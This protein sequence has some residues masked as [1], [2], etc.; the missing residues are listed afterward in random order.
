MGGLMSFDSVPI[1]VVLL[2]TI[3]LVAL[4]LEAGIRLGRR[5]QRQ[6]GGKSEVSGAMVGATMGLL[7]FMLAFTFNGAAGRHDTRKGLV[8]E[9]TNA[10]DKA[11]LRAG[12]LD[13]PSRAAV[14][15][16]LRNYVDL[17]VKAAGG[18]M[19]LGEAARRSEALLDKMWA[20]AEEVGK[21]EPA[22]I[23]AGLF[24][25][26]LNEVVDLHLKRV[27]VG[28]RNRVPPTIWATLYVLMAIGMLMMGIQIGLTGIRQAGLELALAISFS[29]VL[30]LIADLDR[31]Q[32]GLINVSQQAMVELQLKLNA[33]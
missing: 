29:V 8:I 33:R 23:T 16:L 18:R 12:F 30:F 32:E 22:S 14:R 19:D 7:A 4:A 2:A 15:G 17:R 24:I 3:G 10:I 5:R 9:E 26:A 25:Q 1:W 28:I 13:D 11:W 20:M 21:K 27:T 6:A 31:P